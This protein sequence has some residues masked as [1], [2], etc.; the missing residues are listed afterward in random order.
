[1]NKSGKRVE[2]CAGIEPCKQPHQQ[3]G[4]NVVLHEI[5]QRKLDAVQQQN[6]REGWIVWSLQGLSS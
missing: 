6:E 2:D 3:V 1:M 5:P 4:L